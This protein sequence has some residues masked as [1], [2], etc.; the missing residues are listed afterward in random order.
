MTNKEL[1]QRTFSHAQSAVRIQWEDRRKYRPLRR[2]AVIAAV[3]CALAAL[4]VTAVAFNFLGLRDLLLDSRQAE[5][6][7][8]GLSGYADTAEAKALSEWKAFL[9]GYDSDHAILDSI[10]NEL[11]DLPE[12]FWLYG[13]YTREMDNKLEEIAGKYGL[14][15]HTRRVELETP[16]RCAELAGGDFLGNNLLLGGY[17]LEDGTFL[18]D[19][20][21][22]LP[23]W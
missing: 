18:L 10:G 15:L 14:Q 23:D 8:I 1:Y 5:R 7:I 16:E 13:V 20:E 17:M 6:N 21:V 9:A 22:Q 12:R 3:I 11:Q 2:L 19:M 4:S